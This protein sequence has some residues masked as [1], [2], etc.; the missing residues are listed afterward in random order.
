MW[1][2]ICSTRR[3]WTPIASYLS[4]RLSG[5]GDELGWLTCVSGEREARGSTGLALALQ[6]CYNDSADASHAEGSPARHG[7]A[8][9]KP[10]AR[11]A[12]GTG[13]E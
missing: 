12:D 6:V 3:R 8:A 10:E 9:A 5:A 11:L 13:T 4:D 1:A 2:T 7:T